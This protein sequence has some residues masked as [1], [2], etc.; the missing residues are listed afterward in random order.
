MRM[1]PLCATRLSWAALCLMLGSA[2]AHAVTPAPYPAV[3]VLEAAKAA[4]A[5][6]G[7]RADTVADLTTNGWMPI[8]L[9]AGSSLAQ[10]LEI[11]KNAG[12]KAVG[13]SGSMAETA[14][15]GK[16][17]ENEDLVI[18]LSGV[19]TD[20]VTVNGCRLYDAGETRPLPVAEA[21]RWIA[22][23]PTRSDSNEVFSIASWSPGLV[24]G[25]DSFDLYFVP[26]KSPLVEVLKVSG[27]AIRMDQV[28]TTK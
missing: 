16:T 22:R 17:V 26:S 8:S 13:P 19:T 4:C 20:G 6:L 5:R 7:K 2:S 24:K 28:S 10:L 18:I 15:Y 1:R 21:E 3:A 12:A 9:P 25:Q 14:V 23:A 27:V 11:G